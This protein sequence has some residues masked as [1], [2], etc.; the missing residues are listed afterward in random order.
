MMFAMKA[1]PSKDNLLQGYPRQI[2]PEM[3]GIDISSLTNRNSS[4]L[5]LSHIRDFSPVQPGLSAERTW[6]Y[7]E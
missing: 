3:P 7:G 6:R 1:H 5:F 4:H 2:P